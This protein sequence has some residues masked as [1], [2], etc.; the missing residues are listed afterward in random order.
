VVKAADAKQAG[1]CSKGMGMTSRPGRSQYTILV[2]RDTVTTL[3]VSAR[4]TY[5]GLYGQFMGEC[6]SYGFLEER[7]EQAIRGR[8][9]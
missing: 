5:Y 7:L 3:R 9:Q 1:E 6:A 4:L 2:S 8:V